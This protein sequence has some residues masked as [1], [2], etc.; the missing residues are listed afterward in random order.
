MGTLLM[1]IC[2][3][4]ALTCIYLSAVLE[5]LFLQFLCC[6]IGL[7]LCILG[8]Y[9]YNNYKDADEIKHDEELKEKANRRYKCPNC[10]AIAGKKIS[11][12]S[13]DVSITIHGAASDK[14][15]KNYEC[16]KCGYLW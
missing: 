14:I 10:G 12:L 6:I 13:K 8:V 11:T 2:L 1:W 4:P 5:N 9:L 15:G 16:E 3:I 7:G